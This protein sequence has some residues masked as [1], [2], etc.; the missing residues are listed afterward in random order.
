MH[1]LGK[2][3]VIADCAVNLRHPMRNTP[4]ATAD[5]SVFPAKWRSQRYGVGDVLHRAETD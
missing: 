3:A 1:G 4:Y 2:K 5:A